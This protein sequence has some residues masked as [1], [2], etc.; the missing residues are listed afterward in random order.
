MGGQ[1]Q[2]PPHEMRSERT[3]M[4]SNMADD[5]FAKGHELIRTVDHAAAALLRP[6]GIVQET[7]EEEEGEVGE[8]GE[9]VEEEV[10][11]GEGVEGVEGVEGSAG[12]Q[13]NV[14]KKREVERNVGLVEVELGVVEEEE[15]EEEEEDDEECNDALDGHDAELWDRIVLQ[16]VSMGFSK[17]YGSALKD[18]T[19]ECMKYVDGNGCGGGGEVDHVHRKEAV[20]MEGVK[21]HEDVV[22]LRALLKKCGIPVPEPGSIV[23]R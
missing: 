13:G 18:D 2:P 5:P 3:S 11:V 17:E 12:T 23:Y 19:F 6:L 4:Y 7:A 9:L 21:G 15:Q 8:L 14:E 20:S 10:V 22:F 1:Q 16:R